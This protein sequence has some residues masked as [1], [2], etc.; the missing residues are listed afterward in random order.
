LAV[1]INDEPDPVQVNNNLT[2]RIIVANNGPDAA[3]DA[4]ATVTLPQGVMFVSANASQGNC[5]GSGP[6]ACT[7]GNLAA[8]AKATITV[9]VKPTATG[10]LTLQANVSSA[11]PDINTAN[12]TASQT[13]RVSTLLSIF[14]RVTTASGEG[15]SG[16][17][18]SLIGTQQA[19]ITTNSDGYYQ[20]AELPAGSYVVRPALG[21][22][23][24]NPANHTFSN[25]ANDQ[26]ADFAAVSCIFSIA[27]ANRVFQAEGG[28]GSL[29]INSPDGQCPW[30]ARSNAAWI[31][32]EG[33]TGG[34]VSGNGT[35]TINFTVEPT[36]GA[37]SGT[38]IVGGQ[39]FT[40]LQEFN[41]CSTVSFDASPVSVL[42]QAGYFLRQLAADFNNDGVIDL[43]AINS[44]V[45]TSQRDISIVIYPRTAAG[46][47]GAPVKALTLQGSNV[48]L[49][50]FASGELN[51]DGFADF[52]AFGGSNQNLIYLV[53]SN[54]TGGFAAPKELAAAL[55]LSSIAIA[56]FNSDGKNDAAFGVNSFENN[57]VVY[58][59]DG[60]GNLGQ[61]KALPKAGGNFFVSK[62][63]AADFNGDG[64]TDIV[65]F[66]NGSEFV[67]YTNNG[68]GE[69]MAQVQTLP[70]STGDRAVGDFNGDGRPDILFSL[71][72]GLLLYLNDGGGFGQPLM[73]SVGYPFINTSAPAL[74][75]GDF[76]GDGKTDAAILP[77]NATN[78]VSEGL[79]LFTATGGG[80]GNFSPP[81][82]YLPTVGGSATAAG[83]VFATAADFNGDGLNDLL[84]SKNNSFNNITNVSI[85]AGLKSGGLSAARAFQLSTSDS[86]SQSSPNAIAAADLNGDG[87]TDLA[88]TNFSSDKVSLL[89]GDGRGGFGSPVGVAASSGT[90]DL[91]IRDFNRDGQLDLA[92]LS[93]SPNIITILLGNGRGE[94][95]KGATVNVGPNARRL[96]VADFNRDGNP[97]LVAREQGGGLAVWLG[98]GQGGFA[99]GATG[100]GGN[101]EDFDQT[102]VVGDFNGDANADLAIADGNQSGAGPQLILLP[103]NGQGGFGAAI[104]MR[105]EGRYNLLSLEDLNA[106]GR[107]DLLYQYGNFVH[108]MLSR[109]DGSFAAPVQYAVGG[110]VRFASVRD[111]NGDARPDVLAVSQ[112][113][114]AIYVFMGKGDGSFNPS[115]VIPAPG[116]P[117]QLAA[118]DFDGDGAVD[119]AVM[120]GSSTIGTVLLNRP[121]CPPKGIV[122][123]SAAS[124]ARYQAA[125]ESIVAL[126]GADLATT[127]QVATTVPLPTALAGVSVKVRDAAGVERASPLFFVSP[128]QINFQI[129]VGTAT[130]TALLTVLRGSETVSTGTATINRVAPALFAADASGQGFPAAVVL[131]VKANGAQLFEP[132]VALDATGKLIGVPVDLSVEG[133][134]VFLLLFGTG[135]RN[136]SGV[137]NVSAK[138]GSMLVEVQYAGAQ[139]DFVG[140]DQINL[141]LPRVLA[142]LGT[143]EL[144]LT[145]DGRAANPLKIIIK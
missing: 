10:S 108:V 39:T 21:G 133:D 75:T 118:E 13:T 38:I 76:N 59:N 27:P 70:T 78:S 115:V 2:Y 22:Y 34:V 136:N 67:V 36:V 128:G 40:V 90:L 7:L 130:G 50:A 1:T 117:R 47:F 73:T 104:R 71:R 87:V 129:P 82:W 48:S 121:I 125:P 139:G 106:D 4:M 84:F 138:A 53:L 62:I 94:F 122:T 35:R 51:G 134:Q 9:V 120:R 18:V 124:Y 17:S 145:V 19:T 111:V 93:S 15:L 101:L 98:N 3:A 81:V 8:L 5:T 91:V 31:R 96:G 137:V 46:G 56:D 23:V 110:D 114:D 77:S 80:G 20:F 105:V 112:S 144:L 55:P 30:T 83:G 102:F 72:D 123:T 97:D 109:S 54:G 103:G 86:G 52:V 16:V 116:L 107:G 63:E 29:T 66:A 26:R 95:A 79:L 88:T 57:V 143:A 140:L 37:R 100:L 135:I 43:A 45:A 92:V 142:G 11:T 127:T 32:L 44:N 49:Q 24:F 61:P 85:A 12:N 14:G 141:R 99:V 74:V 69:F 126:F 6:V 65:S 89:F 60:A 58:F 41:P 113:A 42:P 132:V 64:K 119:L 28:A 25:V 131:R 68:A 33:A